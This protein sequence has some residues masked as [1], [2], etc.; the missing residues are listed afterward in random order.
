MPTT[1]YKTVLELGWDDRS[2][3]AGIKRLTSNIDQL[4]KTLEEAFA[5]GALA[6]MNKTLDRT[7]KLMESVA[8][9]QEKQARGARAAPAGSAAAMLTGMALGTGRGM[10]GALDARAGAALHGGGGGALAGGA[11][12]GGR[13][14]GRAASGAAGM[15]GRAGGMMMNEG[16]LGSMMGGI[17]WLGPIFA[18]ATGAASGY[19]AQ[20]M[21]RE[22]ARTSAYGTTGMRQSEFGAMGN[23]YGLGPTELPGIVG[24]FAESAG[25][26]GRDEITGSERGYGGMFG[27]FGQAADIANLLGIDYGAT[28]GFMRA[29]GSAALGGTPGGRSA[30]GETG[31]V[32]ETLSAAIAAGV[33]ESQLG[34]VLSNLSST[35]ED[36]QTR[37]FMVAPDSLNALIRGLGAG[38]AESGFGG[39]AGVRA[40]TG[41]TEGMRGV[42]TREN[43]FE[44][45]ALQEAGYG[46]GE[47]YMGARQRLE[48][49]PELV[50]APLLTR[51]RGMGDEGDTEGRMQ[52]LIEGFDALGHHLS[53]R[54]ARSLMGAGGEEMISRLAGAGSSEEFDRMLEERRSG[55]EFGEVEADA[56]LNESRADVGARIAGDV[57]GISRAEIEV[58]ERLLPSV[59][60]F[61]HDVA[62]VG[63]EL[64]HIFDEGGVG[65]LLRHFTD[66]V[67]P[68]VAEE[69][70]DAVDRAATATGVADVAQALDAVA[71]RRDIVSAFQ[72]AMDDVRAWLGLGRAPRVTGIRADGSE[73]YSTEGG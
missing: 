7:A 30:I 53:V 46:N 17:P 45:L 2:P 59:T 24:S 26:R 41:M 16:M 9:A 57:R 56:A 10:L 28:G 51:L 13:G 11:W 25:L 33:E 68:D 21:G 71:L 29:S 32:A 6:E 15:A 31:A 34:Q 4:G 36:L 47:T 69:A 38:G 64:L 37:G 54:Q 72:G 22:R 66:V 43:L 70:G 58:V 63:M 67:M 20:H 14:I 61:M 27:R 18:G 55:A 73:I 60:G 48:E 1:T 44:M 40:A 5:G 35:F 12:L 65:G 50:L 8:K 42:G 19:Y 23:Q 49:H 3:Q 39:M 52:M 62:D